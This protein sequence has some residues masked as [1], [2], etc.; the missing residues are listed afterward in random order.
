[1]AVA[2]MIAL[3]QLAAD[4]LRAALDPRVREAR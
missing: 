3:A 1:M 2:T 4:L